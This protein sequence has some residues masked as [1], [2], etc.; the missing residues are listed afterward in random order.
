MPHVARVVAA[1]SYRRHIME[2]MTQSA[3]SPECVPPLVEDWAGAEFLDFE[4]NHWGIFDGKEDVVFE[5]FGLG[6]P[7][8]YQRLYLECGRV[9][10]LAYDAHLVRMILDAADSA[11]ALRTGR[12]GDSR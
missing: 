2:E 9:E 10:A 8:Y 6:L 12:Q 5:R 3:S 1:F 4:R 7:A 11:V